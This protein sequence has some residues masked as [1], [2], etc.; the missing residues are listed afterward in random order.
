MKL[1]HGT[2]VALISLMLL[3]P[4][5][6]AAEE[7]WA[8]RITFSGDL[9]LRYEVI[10]LELAEKRDRARYRARLAMAMQASDSVSLVMQLASGAEDPVSRNVT[11]DGGFSGDDIGFDLVYADWT[12]AE[13]LHVLAGKMK[14]PLY[15]AGGNSMTWDSDL[16]P[17]GLAL[18]YSK[19]L[20]FGT[21]GRFWVEERASD[22]DSTLTAVQLG[23]KFDVT[24][25]A[26]ITA[27]VGYF[28]FSN[29]VGNTPFYNGLP[30]GNSVDTQLLYL[31]EYKDT[32]VFL[33]FDTKVGDMPLQLFAH[34]TRNGEVDEQDNGL[35]Y[36]ARLGSAKDPGQW[37]VALA[38][39][40]I[41]ADSL[42][43]TFNDSDFG[44][45]GTGANGLIFK[46]RYVVAKNIALAGSYFSNTVN[47]NSSSI[48]SLPELD[49]DRL[50]LDVEFRFN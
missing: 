19:G 26:V 5:S 22:D 9:R 38:Y 33:Q 21:A 6:N 14:N 25:N 16:N 12:A 49:Y 42:L 34:T 32:E 27:G 28:A 37:E 40:D 36:G 41:E 29:T 35:A 39:H 10:E 20:F 44:G 47:A 23:G 48:S 3:A 7:N 2:C 30:K 50:Q 24:E 31:Y 45:G 43:G 17:E 4:A 1:I 18:T 15:R 8:D 46:T 13:G 11:F